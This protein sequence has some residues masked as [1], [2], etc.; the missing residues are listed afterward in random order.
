MDTEVGVISFS[1]MKKTVKNKS[2]KN[3]KHQA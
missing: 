2:M 1:P 3:L